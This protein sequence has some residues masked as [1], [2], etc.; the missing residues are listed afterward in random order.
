MYKYGDLFFISILDITVKCF[1]WSKQ[2]I[3]RS[4][5]R[6]SIRKL[7]PERLRWKLET[8]IQVDLI[9]IG[10]ES[11]R[12]I[13]LVHDV[14]EFFHWQAMCLYTSAQPWGSTRGSLAMSE[15]VS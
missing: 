12:W 11:G 4:L 2:E 13:E 1:G 9:E 7:S 8:V 15:W 14:H 3:Y 10:H 6:K 5:C